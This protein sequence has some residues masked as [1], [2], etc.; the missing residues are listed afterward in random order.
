VLT[1][2]PGGFLSTPAAAAKGLPM[3]HLTLAVL[4]LRC[5]KEG[6]AAEACST[7]CA[8]GCSTGCAKG[9]SGT[10]RVISFVEHIDRSKLEALTM[11]QQLASLHEGPSPQA[12]VAAGQERLAAIQLQLLLGGAAWHLSYTHSMRG[13]MSGQQVPQENDTRGKRVF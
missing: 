5:P 4:Q 1:G 9:C 10:Q 12:R 7:G 6:G 2:W 8:E 3:L 11:V 13:G